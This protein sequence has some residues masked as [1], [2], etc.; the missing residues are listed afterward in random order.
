VP[1]TCRGVTGNV[2]PLLI[3]CVGAAGQEL[4]PNPFGPHPGYGP[5]PATAAYV[6]AVISLPQCCWSWGLEA[7]GGNGGG[8]MLPVVAVGMWRAR[9]GGSPGSRTG[10]CLG[11]ACHL[12]QVTTV[13]SQVSTRVTP[14]STPGTPGTPAIPVMAPN[15]ELSHQRQHQQR[16]Q[17]QALARMPSPRS[18]STHDSCR[19]K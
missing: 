2:R 13:G 10:V 5:A 14:V 8:V 11:T 6:R 7:E 18:W 3:A 15:G 19:S 4:P 17:A 9:A 1:V 12:G 16:A